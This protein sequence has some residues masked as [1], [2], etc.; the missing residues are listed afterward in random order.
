[1]AISAR[2]SS[3]RSP[4]EQELH[5][6]CNCGRAL[7][8]AMRRYSLL[9]GG[10][11]HKEVERLAYGDTVA[12]VRDSAMELEHRFNPVR[13]PWEQRCFYFLNRNCTGWPL[14]ELQESL[15]WLHS[16]LGQLLE[17]MDWRELTEGRMVILRPD[18]QS[19][20]DINH[21]GDIKR[22]FDPK[23]F[24][25]P[26]LEEPFLE[27][28]E[29]VLRNLF[30]IIQAALWQASPLELE[31]RTAREARARG[32]AA[33]SGG[34]WKIP[35]R[36][37]TTFDCFSR[38]AHQSHAE[39]VRRSYLAQIRAGI[40][41][42]DH[43]A[44]RFGL[45]NDPAAHSVVRPEFAAAAAR[46]GYLVYHAGLRLWLKQLLSHPVVPECPVQMENWLKLQNL[47]VEVLDDAC[48]CYVPGLDDRTDRE[49]VE[50]GR[51]LFEPEQNPPSPS[52]D[53]LERFS[54]VALHETDWLTNPPDY[55]RSLL[56]LAVQQQVR[57]GRFLVRSFAGFLPSPEPKF[58]DIQKPSDVLDALAPITEWCQSKI[59]QG[60]R[61]DSSYDEPKHSDD[62]TSVIWYGEK[63]EFNK[64][65]AEAI[66][67]L[68][69][70]WEKGELALSEKTV[71]EKIGSDNN[72][73]KL[74]HT[75]RTNGKRHPA[76]GTMIHPLGKGK[77]R[78][79]APNH[80]KIPK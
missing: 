49:L 74:A 65:Q 25:W 56:N 19:P 26:A 20:R 43:V 73:Y 34:V 71:G 18:E 5:N 4:T 64:T 16:M 62:F 46:L 31:L 68:W 47:A 57:G 15:A 40:D 60:G 8:D 32:E 27:R 77:Y 41:V 24:V 54:S 14:R 50:L 1:M 37:Y 33:T 22:F 55:F 69:A 53:A 2:E 12:A 66:K 30:G 59:N 80:Q 72:N 9:V 67:H 10:R 21:G 35:A 58:E 52:D 61:S 75:F 7:L 36:A 48:R 17:T 78:L 42:L 70:E 76:L 23:T 63:H 79:G 29:A 44:L 3:F 11:A 51:F 38:A 39:W 13:L 28:F 6:V 45:A